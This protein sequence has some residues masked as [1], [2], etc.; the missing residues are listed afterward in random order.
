MAVTCTSAVTHFSE[1]IDSNYLNDSNDWF[2][3]CLHTVSPVGDK[4]A[5]WQGWGPSC[6]VSVGERWES[7]ATVELIWWWKLELTFCS[8]EGKEDQLRFGV[9][10]DCTFWLFEA[11]ITNSN[12]CSSH[13]NLGF[14][15][16]VG[17]NISDVQFME[18]IG[19]KVLFINPSRLFCQ[20]MMLISDCLHLMCKGSV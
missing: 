5:W 13:H 20:V 15:F 18:I 10:M 1:T 6:G 17:F 11:I 9:L 8:I 12:S 3:S 16:I 4:V 14:N 2:E 19:S 7:V